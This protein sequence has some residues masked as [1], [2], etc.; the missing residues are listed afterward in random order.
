[1]WSFAI[2]DLPVLSKADKRCYSH[3]RKI[4]LAEGFLMLQFSVY[5]RYCESRENMKTLM[6]RIRSELPPHGEVRFLSVTDKQFADMTVYNGRK[7]GKPEDKPQQM[8]LF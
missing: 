4:L 6:R 8:M 1:M 2:F 7:Y 3:F 5:A